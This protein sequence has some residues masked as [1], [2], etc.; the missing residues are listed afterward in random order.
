PIPAPGTRVM[1]AALRDTGPAS[2]GQRRRL[3]GRTVRGPVR[4]CTATACRTIHHPFGRYQAIWCC[5]PE[6]PGDH[7]QATQ[8]TP[9][10]ADP[11]TPGDSVSY[12]NPQQ[13]LQHANQYQQQQYQQQWTPPA[14]RKQKSSK[15]HWFAY[16]AVALVFLAIGIAAGGG[17]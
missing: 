10:P 6:L 8:V 12:P 7:R 1:P 15:L 3:Q 5:S 9:D 16:P 13:Q 4:P 14:P 2:S 17:G 11:L